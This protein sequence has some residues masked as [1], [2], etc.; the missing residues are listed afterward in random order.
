MKLLVQAFPILLVGVVA[1][2][3]ACNDATVD[4]SDAT[5]TV[6]VGDPVPEA[7]NGGQPDGYCN[8]L[9]AVPETCSCFDCVE[10]AYCLGTCND[11]GTCEAG[12]DCTCADCFTPGCEGPDDDDDADGTDGTDGPPPTTTGGGMGGTPSTGG[13]PS[14]G[15]APGVGGMGGAPPSNGGGGMGGGV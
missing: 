15:G 6:T 5:G 2:H 13:A 9:G 1:V 3:A 10:T 14:S 11:N 8:S 4:D 7:C 12:E